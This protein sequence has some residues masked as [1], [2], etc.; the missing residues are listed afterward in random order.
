MATFLRSIPG[1]SS[2][3]AQHLEFPDHAPEELEEIAQ[4]MLVGMQYRLSPT[5]LEALMTIEGEDL[6]AGRMLA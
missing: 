3:I 4:R 6:R 2:P 1:L 5:G